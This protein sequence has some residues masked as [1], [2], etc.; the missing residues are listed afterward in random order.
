MVF[1]IYDNFFNKLNSSRCFTVNGTIDTM[2]L[3]MKL[4]LIAKLFN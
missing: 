1:H 2:F 3:K 4:I